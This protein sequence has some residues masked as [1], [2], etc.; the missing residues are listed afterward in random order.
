M[1]NSF[2]RRLLIAAIAWLVMTC[3]ICATVR[4][5]E[6]TPA[7]RTAPAALGEKAPHDPGGGAGQMHPEQMADIRDIQGPVHIPS[8]WDYAGLFIAALI[9]AAIAGIAVFVAMRYR[10][11]RHIPTADEI[12][13]AQLAQAGQLI[14]EG[15]AKEFCIQV[16]DC[17]RTYIES[18]FHQR[19]A[20]RTTEEFLNDMLTVEGHEL[21]AHKELLADFLRYCDLAKFAKWS[22]S[23]EEMENMLGAARKFVEETRAPQEAASHP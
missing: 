18:R 21:G 22:F 13:L 11:R 17:V 2:S 8:L 3:A 9:G 16:S 7:Q 4:A 6:S 20:H 12:A 14:A 23:S 19:A 1:M 5:D 10:S 15:Q